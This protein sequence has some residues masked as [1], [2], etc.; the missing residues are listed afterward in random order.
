MN[1]QT[2]TFVSE[3]TTCEA[4]H[5]V[6]ADDS[7]ATSA[8]RPVVV[9]AHGLG[10]TRD[11]GLEPFARGFA[12][13]GLDVLAFDYRGFGGSAGFPRQTVSLEG[14]LADFRAAMKA[15]AALPGVDPTRIVLW[16]VSLAGG[17][18]LRAAADRTDVAAV[19]SVVPM[20]DGIAAAVHATATHTKSELLRATARGIRGRVSARA[21][22]GSVMMPIVAR[23]GEIG[24]MT[25]PGALEDYLAIAGPTWRNEIAADV[26]LELGSRKPQADAA[27]ITCPLLVQI[28]DFDQSA[29]PY[30]SAKAAFKGKAEVRH[31]PCDHFDIFEGKPWHEPALAHAV[32]F[33][34]RHLTPS[35]TDTAAAPALE[36]IDA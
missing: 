9:M 18:V 15:A 26:A 32:S 3:G 34:V 11:S 17:H 12:A 1:L 13:A 31:Y 14:Q 8:G 24:A 30:A 2:L 21:G 22:R 25:L 27:R 16:G 35:A 20:V 4:T 33:L 7:L 6:A 10:G 23:P 19:V 29:P 28:A 36:V 5:Y